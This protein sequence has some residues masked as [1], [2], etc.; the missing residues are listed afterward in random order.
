M[1]AGISSNLLKDR[2]EKILSLWVERSL[3]EV[4]SAVTA[5]ALALRNSLPLYL[6][7]L[8]EAL[9][10]N[11]KMDVRS[12]LAH[13]KEG[14]RIGRLHGADRAGNTSYVLTE[15]I[16]EYHIL[17]EVIFQVLE[18]EEQLPVIH[19]DIIL[20]SIEQAVNDAAVKF[21]EVH[22]DIQQRF[23]NTLTHDLK[24]PI[25]AAKLSAQLILK[26]SENPEACIE[27]GSRVIGRMNRLTSMIDDLL[28][29]GRVRA[30]EF[31]QLQFSECDLR[32]VCEEVV[33]E[34]SIVH[35]RTFKFN[36]SGNVKGVWGGDGVRRALENLVGNAVKYGKMT[37]LITI[38]LEEIKSGV[39]I[40]VHNEGTPIP[41][42]E[43]SSLFVNYRRSKSAESGTQ[44]GWGLGLTLVKGVADAHKGTI[45]VTSGEGE[46][47]TF[48]RTAE[49]LI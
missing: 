10:T 29:A 35:N 25:S 13:D 23:I 14:I 2:Q 18:T 39:R 40:S 19:R 38:K 16:F 47:T 43:I 48:I 31:L 37:G 28:D 46:G 36:A 5:E 24:T 7:H 30:G 34:M 44:G 20:D 22:A 49:F 33:D 27:L 1:M 15:V 17:R 11:R 8:S 4:P 32:M 41:K 9:A 3:K 45:Q 26:K 42:E 12:V 6:D 21:S